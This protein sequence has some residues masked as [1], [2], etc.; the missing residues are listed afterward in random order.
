M[1]IG[2]QKWMVARDK[3]SDLLDDLDEDLWK[4]AS[5]A[6]AADLNSSVRHEGQC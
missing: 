5:V 3:I 4:V 6:V 1:N 2:K